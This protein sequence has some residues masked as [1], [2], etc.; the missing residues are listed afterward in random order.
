MSYNKYDTN[1]INSIIV[2]ISILR[3]V[4]STR[5]LVSKSTNIISKHLLIMSKYSLKG[6]AL[7]LSMMWTNKLGMNSGSPCSTAIFLANSL[8]LAGRFRLNRGIRDISCTVPSNSQDASIVSPI[9]YKEPRY[10]FYSY[11][12]RKRS[13]I[14]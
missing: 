10:R 2:Q 1:E 3:P 8:K 5:M 7:E 6:F 11:L 13:R 14:Q 4:F 9:K 12:V